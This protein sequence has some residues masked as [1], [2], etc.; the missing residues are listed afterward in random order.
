MDTTLKT[1]PSTAKPLRA[2]MRETLPNIYRLGK[3]VKEISY[4][5]AT[6]CSPSRY[7]LRDQENFVCYVQKYVSTHTHRRIW[8]ISKNSENSVLQA[9]YINSIILMSNDLM[10][11]IT[12]NGLLFSL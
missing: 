5:D 12:I 4:Q 8:K 6:A 10:M 2:Q 9:N 7:S 11:D 1:L 3:E